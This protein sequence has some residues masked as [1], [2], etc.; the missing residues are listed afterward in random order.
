MKNAYTESEAL[1]ARSNAW[2]ARYI[3]TGEITSTEM[4]AVSKADAP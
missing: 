4:I 3:A 1:R 2:F